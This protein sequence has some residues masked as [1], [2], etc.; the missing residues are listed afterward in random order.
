LFILESR[1]IANVN[2]QKSKMTTIHGEIVAN[3]GCLAQK[4]VAFFYFELQNLAQSPK[5]LRLHYPSSLKKISDDSCS[6]QS[7]EN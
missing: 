3:G 4:V 1:V 7:A 5:L 6:L 2:I